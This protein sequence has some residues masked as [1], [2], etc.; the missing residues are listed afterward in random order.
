MKLFRFGP[1]SPITHYSSTRATAT[2]VVRDLA[3]VHLTWIRLEAGGQLGNHQAVKNQLFIVIHRD[4]WVQTEAGAKM[5]VGTGQAAFW[6]AG[7]WHTSGTDTGMMVLVLES[8]ALDAAHIVG[9]G[10]SP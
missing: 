6:Q 5:A 7:E 2:P 8:D 3:D 1:G 9:E 10:P 4:G